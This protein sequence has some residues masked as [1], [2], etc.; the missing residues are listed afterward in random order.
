MPYKLK[1][2]FYRIPVMGAGDILTEEQEWIQ[3]S[4]IDNLL[5]AATFGCKKAFLEEGAYGLEWSGNHAECH[6]HIRPSKLGGYSLLGI[7]N[8]RMFLSREDISIGTLYRDEIYHVYVEYENGLE[9]DALGF[10]VK[11]YIA[12]Q[13][14]ND[15][16]MLLCIVDTHGEGSVNTDVDKV[17]A[18]NIL[19]HTMDTTNP[20]GRTMTQDN[21]AVVE[22]L[23]V[24]GNP[25]NG[26]EYRTAVT[27]GSGSSVTIEF[28]SS[29]PLFVTVYPESLGAG[30]I[31]WAINGSS[32][33]ISNAGSAGIRLNIRAD[34]K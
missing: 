12:K 3:M 14:E 32:V 18:K 16:R 4:T 11:A 5:H 21:L 2:D 9:T 6:L 10:S 25:V 7:I 31:A 20:H 27:A 33:S 22:T 34:V 26:V 19:A 24:N 1:T 8:C 15:R 17:Y 30:E 23:T 28:T 13:Q 29:V